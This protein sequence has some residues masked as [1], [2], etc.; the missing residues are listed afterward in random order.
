MTYF[1]GRRRCPAG[2]PAVG[3]MITGSRQLC[4]PARV[5][6]AAGSGVR[7]A[8]YGVSMG[9]FSAWLLLGGSAS[10]AAPRAEVSSGFGALL[11]A[12]A[13][14]LFGAALWALRRQAVQARREAPLRAVLDQLPAMVAFVDREQRYR[15]VNGNY[16]RWL[17][18]APKQMLG[19]T[20][21]ELHG[22]EHYATLAPQLERAFAGEPV[23]L[24]RRVT[25][26]GP[27]KNRWLSLA[28]TP[29]FDAD[30][31]VAGLHV[32]SHDV[33]DALS[34]A[35]RASF[36]AEHDELTTL[37]NRAAFHAALQRS[38]ARAEAGGAPFA[39][40][41]IDVDRFKVVN[42]TLGHAAGD[43]LLQMMAERL[44]DAVRGDD[45]VARMGG[46]EMALLLHG[47][48]DGQHAGQ[49]VERLLGTL[50][51]PFQL[52]GGVQHHATASA[53]IAL[54]PGDGGDAETLLRHA[55]I[56][57]YRAK[58]LGR[59]GHALFDAREGQPA[60]AKLALELELRA[61]IEA[62]QL[63]LHFQPRVEML[64]G[65]AVGVEALVRWQHPQRG[66]LAPAHFIDIAE[67]T[68]LVVPMG[69]W[70]LR[71]AGQA[72]KRL[73]EAGAPELSISVN[74]SALQFKHRQLVD[75]VAAMIAVAGCDPGRIE[76]ELTESAVMDQPEAAAAT[77]G[78]LKAL[79]VRLAMDDFGTGHS[80]LAALKRFPMDC[81]KID[82]SFVNDIATDADD[83]ALTRAIIAMGHSLGLHVVAEGVE[84]AEQLEF[85]RREGCDEY[86]GYYYARP[87]PEAALAA[88]LVAEERPCLQ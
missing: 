30:G 16:E 81:V 56:A 45:L 5:H 2:R 24:Q 62:G 47:V 55:D 61:A 67:E 50:R 77:M 64:S 52:S 82:R 66:L 28:Y 27:A 80:S 11:V 4:R 69:S 14:L 71:H 60:E 84:R 86:Q 43:R 83:A 63:V 25:H 1:T 26:D 58:A 29:H 9:L 34:A 42:S 22:E 20:L 31:R 8:A 51:V 19:R 33:T 39:V 10:A 6:E 17:G 65:R 57:M 18:L 13:A 41:L 75:E 12:A 15:Y 54:Y 79:G 3:A 68:G 36:L 40:I 78:G 37:P 48:S 21:R 85:L 88:L 87:M 46:D 53:G 49:V 32:V 44:K 76:L 35:R 59:D 38:L 74:V 73:R 72:L 70:V 23:A 7:P